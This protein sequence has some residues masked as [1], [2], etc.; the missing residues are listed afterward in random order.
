MSNFTQAE[1]DYI[2]S[3]QLGRLATVNEAGEPHVAP[4]GFTYNAELDTIDISGRNM[5][6]SKKFRDAAKQGR[7]AFVIDDVL[8]PW[9]PRGIEIRGRAEAHTAGGQA[10]NANFDAEIIRIFPTRIIGWGL[11][12]DAYRPNSRP[13]K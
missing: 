3:Q 10:V 9:K 11:D 7:V 13:V 12:T 6:K 4:V 2:Q 1:I 8:P 5:S